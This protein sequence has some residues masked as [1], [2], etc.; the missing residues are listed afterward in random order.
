MAQKRIV[1]PDLLHRNLRTGSLVLVRLARRARRARWP[2][3]LRRWGS[4]T[5]QERDREAYSRKNQVTEESDRRDHRIPSADDLSASGL[6]DV[7]GLSL[8]PSR[9]RRVSR[10]P[11]RRPRASRDRKRR[12][13]HQAPRRDEHNEGRARCGCGV[14]TLTAGAVG[15]GRGVQTEHM[16]GRSTERGKRAEKAPACPIARNARTRR[17]R[18]RHEKQWEAS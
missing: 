6:S 13:R 10:R 17:S 2:A 14:L 16:H 8:Q 9:R 4:G 5:S 1:S 3:S 18:D 12:L 7:H 15:D 11:R